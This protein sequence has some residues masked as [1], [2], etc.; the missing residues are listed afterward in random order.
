MSHSLTYGNLVC[1]IP[2]LVATFGEA[3]NH[4]IFRN[5]SLDDAQASQCFFQL[6]HRIT[7]FRLRL[8]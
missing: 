2:E 4:F 7:P 3:V 1:R 5:K 6:R 8:Q